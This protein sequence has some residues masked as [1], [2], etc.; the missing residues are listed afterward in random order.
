M[1]APLVG[2]AM[3]SRTN[4]S[5]AG[6]R[7]STPQASWSVPAAEEALRQA[8]ALAELD[9]RLS[10]LTWFEIGLAAEGPP[11]L[12]G[13]AWRRRNRFAAL[14]P[15]MAAGR[16][17][18]AR[19]TRVRALTYLLREVQGLRTELAAK[20][21]LTVTQ[22]TRARWV[23]GGHPGPL[24]DY[25]GSLAGRSG[26]T[27]SAMLDALTIEEGLLVRTLKIVRRVPDPVTRL[28]AGRLRRLSIRQLL[29]LLT[30]AQHEQREH[31]LL[32]GL[33]ARFY[34]TNPPQN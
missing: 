27:A 33:A 26:Q 11:S 10:R 16:T 32:L 20:G 28:A 12:E 3:A 14:H 5:P 24:R 1:P 29:R 22:L 4:R 21:Q 15:D 17:T 34:E 25:F 30:A 9:D 19:A 6:K 23:F 7:A 2:R 8:I 13:G 18:L 31:M